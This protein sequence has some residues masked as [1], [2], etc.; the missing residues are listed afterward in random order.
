MVSGLF[1]EGPTPRDP[2]QVTVPRLERP[3]NGLLQV[4]TAKV[5]F[6]LRLDCAFKIPSQQLKDMAIIR[7]LVRTASQN[8]ATAE[9]IVLTTGWPNGHAS[10]RLEAL[11]VK[12]T[13]EESDPIVATAPG[14]T[15]KEAASET[16]DA[17]SEALVESITEALDGLQT[18]GH[19]GPYA[20]VLPN[21]LWR[22]YQTDLL[23][24]RGRRALVGLL[25]DDVKV[26][27]TPIDIGESATPKFCAGVLL[28]LGNEAF[29]MV[30]TE[31]LD[32]AMVQFDG[33]DLI[34]RVE[35]RFVLRVMDTSAAVIIGTK[36]KKKSAKQ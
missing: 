25:N 11:G 1:P 29:D 5:R 18:D 26:A 10:S 31:P 6:P 14:N 36:P 3:E 2:Y 24:R 17:K 33:G 21:S 9:G 22:L 7:Q 4:S 35:Q 32:I 20:L 30:R 34:M 28:S 13:Q 19:F 16:D 27:R 23:S 12:A 8:V 15:I